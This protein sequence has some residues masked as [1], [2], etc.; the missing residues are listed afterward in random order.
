MDP[1]LNE[2]RMLK[3]PIVLVLDDFHMIKSESIHRVMAYLIHH[4][5][6]SMHIILLTRETVSFPLQHLNINQDLYKIGKEQLCFKEEE[7]KQL[8]SI[9]GAGI[10]TETEMDELNQQTEGWVTA[11]CVIAAQAWSTPGL[12]YPHAI[13]LGLL[14]VFDYLNEELLLTM[15]SEFQTFLLHTSISTVCAQSYAMN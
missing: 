5:P 14:Q 2:L 15:D 10:L 4:L 7:I 6:R 3:E 13:N 12:K 11:M 8:F 9:M 1:L